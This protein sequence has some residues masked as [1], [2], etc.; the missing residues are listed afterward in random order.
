VSLNRYHSYSYI[1]TGGEYWLDVS[2]GWICA[3]GPA[4]VMG[5]LRKAPNSQRVYGEEGG[6]FVC[7]PV[8]RAN[9]LAAE[10]AAS[11]DW[12]SDTYRAA[13]KEAMRPPPEQV[14]AWEQAVGPLRRPLLPHQLE[15]CM[16]A[17]H[18][19]GILNGSERGLGKTG[20]GWV[21][22]AAWN[23]KKTMIVCPKP[24]VGEWVAEL[25]EAGVQ[26]LDGV[27]IITLDGYES[28]TE[29]S[30]LLKALAAVDEP[31][32]VIAYYE[33]L[34]LM[35]E[36]FLEFAPDLVVLDEGW[37]LK[38]PFTKSYRT[39]QEMC[40]HAEHVLIL[41]G[42]VFG[43]HVGDVWTQLKMLL[44]EDM[45]YT[46]EDWM[47]RYCVSP[48]GAPWSSSIR[49]VGC[50]DPC[51]VM[52]EISPFYYR[53][54]KATCE[55]LPPRKWHVVH[56]PYNE[57]QQRT[58]DRLQ[59]QGEAGF[60]DGLSL[61]GARVTKLRLLQ[62]T[63]GFLFNPDAKSHSWAGSPKM[64]WLKQFVSDNLLDDRER[65]LLVWCKFNPEVYKI[66]EE[67]TSL[68]WNAGLPSG[69]GRPRVVAITGGTKGPTSQK[70]DEW[71]RSFNSREDDGVQVMVMQV[72]K[73]CSGHNL[74][75]GDDS[76][77]YSAPWSHRQYEQAN[78]R[79]HRHGRVG[80]V[81]VYK[82]AVPGTED[83]S[84]YACLDRKEDFTASMSPDTY[85]GFDGWE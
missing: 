84:V 79:N 30:D 2:N 48:G 54:T 51:G 45:L 8:S 23:A 81:N 58:Y 3:A 76:V 60:G 63:G 73:M 32:V 13:K 29:K 64:D 17:L 25:P 55:D 66:V 16:H 69:E 24:V 22:A 72:M 40:D 74:Q 68:Y 19:R 12:A 67:L 1:D 47:R 10:A 44:G 42:S 71:K 11:P 7:L 9:L 37:K 52:N 50:V 53:A 56:T 75:A 78:D 26:K 61:A 82:L 31:M 85:S 36:A 14:A 41:S 6:A 65:R 4:K 80:A 35:A 59:E 46:Y 5:K 20:V 34:S 39:A 77:W 38:S 57:H 18:M 83:E 62:L 21:M 43:E 28:V 33:L 49:A 70:V 15:F 27:P